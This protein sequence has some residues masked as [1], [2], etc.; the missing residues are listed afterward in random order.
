[1]AIKVGINGFGRMG[2][3]ICRAAWDWPDIEFVSGSPDRE[4][5]IQIALVGLKVRVGTVPGDIAEQLK[6]GDPP[7]TPWW[8]R[9]NQE[10]SLPPPSTDEEDSSR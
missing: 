7:W 4:Q 1:M 5:G 2:R 6:A 9:T 3:L 8:E 10:E